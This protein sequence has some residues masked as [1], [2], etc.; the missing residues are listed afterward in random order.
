LQ[1]IKQILN[2]KPTILRSVDSFHIYQPIEP[3]SLDE[4]KKFVD[5][6]IGQYPKLQLVLRFPERLFGSFPQGEKLQN[7]F[8]LLIPGTFDLKN[9]EKR[10]EE[11]EEIMLI[12]KWDGYR[13][14]ITNYLRLGHYLCLYS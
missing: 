14:R 1:A 7:P 3:N 4:I 5:N 12:Q 6:V 9:I 10:E 11:R 2:G 8:M 13:P